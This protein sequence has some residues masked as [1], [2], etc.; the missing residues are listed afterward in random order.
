MEVMISLVVAA[1]IAYFYGLAWLSVKAS[2]PSASETESILFTVVIPTLASLAERRRSVA[3][4]QISPV[5][6]PGSK[7]VQLLFGL[8]ALW[9]WRYGGH[10]YICLGS[11]RRGISANRAVAPALTASR[12]VMTTV[13]PLK[14][15][16]RKGA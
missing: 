13:C 6:Q 9:G 11:Q 7:I 1:L 3:P 14:T 5:C 16:V 12:K 4:S 15:N 2:R 8:R 10:K